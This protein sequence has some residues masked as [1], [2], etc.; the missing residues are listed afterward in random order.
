MNGQISVEPAIFGHADATTVWEILRAEWTFGGD[1][2]L[3]EARVGGMDGPCRNVELVVTRRAS[4]RLLQ[5]L[6]TR[7]MDEV[8]DNTARR[9]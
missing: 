2:I 7:A 6:I 8:I 3:I 9:Q 5:L 4:A 1:A